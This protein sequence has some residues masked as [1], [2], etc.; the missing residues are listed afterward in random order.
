MTKRVLLAP[1]KFKGSLAAVEVAVHLIEGI[2]SVAP[3]T[4]VRWVPLADGG[5]GTVAAVVA[6]GFTD[7]P[8][9]AS[10][11]MGMPEPAS[12]A[13]RDGTAVIELATVCGM[14]RLPEGRLEPMTA[15]SFGLGEVV[16]EA[17][18]RGARRVVLGIG[19]SASTD[20]GAGF[21]QAL[22]A[23]VRDGHGTE[24]GR[25]GGALHSAA[26][27]DLAGA[28][29]TMDGV[30][31][32]IASDVDNPLLGPRGAAA[33]YGPQKGA[34]ALDV[35]ELEAALANW[36]A[37][38]ATA[39]GRDD[40]AVPGSG[41]AGGVGFGALTVG[42]SIRSGVA[43]LLEL[44]GFDAM[45]AEADLVVT[46]EGSLDEQTLSG[47][48]PVGVAAAAA[49]HGV[50]VVVVAGSSTL[51]REQMASAGFDDAYL[52][53]DLVDEPQQAMHRAGELVHQQAAAL[54]RR[55]LT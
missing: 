15:S 8:V 36:A 26:T 11:P 13:E 46:G 51:T 44:V 14:Q 30:E 12:Y 49:R 1:D 19:G 25:G 45:L 5:D 41:A 31:L 54:A 10:G 6:A 42:G 27:L 29:A 4:D 53:T 55:W 39:T 52:L 24:V 40:S 32:V 18:G 35:A 21:L 7:V 43:L 22:G 48:T 34:D 38:A 17:V 50:P 33:V 47:K 20:G 2:R 37:V 28:R 16:R 9:I 3:G 23:S